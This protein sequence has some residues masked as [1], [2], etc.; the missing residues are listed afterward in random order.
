ML[1]ALYVLYVATRLTEFSP[2]SLELGDME[3]Q[4]VQALLERFLAR[5]PSAD[6]ATLLRREPGFS[7][8]WKNS[9]GQVE[10]FQQAPQRLRWAGWKRQL[11]WTPPGRRRALVLRFEAPRGLI[12]LLDRQGLQR[13][14]RS[15]LT[16]C[17]LA[18]LGVACVSQLFAD[19]LRRL[20]LLPEAPAP[21]T[22]P[23]VA[24]VERAFLLAA[25]QLA[26]SRSAQ[27]A[28]L[29]EAAA[30]ER[31]K[32]Q[33]LSTISHDLRTPL[34]VVL[35]RLAD[36]DPLRQV[37][38]RLLARL[39]R[40]LESAR[41]E[42]GRVGLH[43]E[44]FEWGEVLESALGRVEGVQ[45]QGDPSRLLRSDFRWLRR[46]LQCLLRGCSGPVEL[47]LEEK[48]VRVSCE[49][50]RFCC[51]EA[52]LTPAEIATVTAALGLNLRL[53]DGAG[54]FTLEFGQAP[55][56]PRPATEP[57]AVAVAP[58]RP[59][60]SGL[61]RRALFFL[62]LCLLWLAAL[63]IATAWLLPEGLQRWNELHQEVAHLRGLPC[64]PPATGL[65]L[66]QPEHTPALRC[67]SLSALTLAAAGPL[68]C[69]WLLRKRLRQLREAG[70]R[71]G[72][73]EPVGASP[74]PELDA[75]WVKL[76]TLQG[77]LGLEAAALQQQLKEVGTEHERRAL[78]L[79]RLQQQLA[80]EL[81][82][83]TES[84]RASQEASLRAAGETLAFLGQDLASA[85]RWERDRWPLE[86]TT[87]DASR[88][89]TQACQQLEPLLQ[90]RGLSWVWESPEGEAEQATTAE[91]AAN[92][93]TAD[94]AT[95]DV[96]TADAATAD[97]ATAVWVQADP[98]R[99][100]Q[101]LQNVLGNALKYAPP[102]GEVTLRWCR[103]GQHTVL[104]VADRGPGL[105]EEVA[106][107]PEREFSQAGEAGRRRLG[108][109]GLGLAIAHRS[110]EMMGGEL[111]LAARPGG[112][113]C[114]G[115]SMRSA[116]NLHKVALDV[117]AAEAH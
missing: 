34:T 55:A 114:V 61:A 50:F 21:G 67:L 5:S 86:M 18:T 41:L 46:L 70:E 73:G 63:A 103:K 94:V 39:E 90:E 97:V 47:S 82:P 15:G 113:S 92:S 53:H 88:F 6:P 29:A 89:V 25:Q 110:L 68:L 65:V 26:A 64:P 36:T 31:H 35:A 59:A 30:G 95:A 83:L 48:G 76:R 107:S 12:W 37:C 54:G 69:F 93:A 77:R 33:V 44:E 20:S 38:T 3:L 4:R 9:A 74:A 72:R 23:D 106:A 91:A 10:W 71:L 96:A 57:A 22:D 28:A 115:L 102:G 62:T 98:R 7:G 112:G 80:P 13:L 45:L 87:L 43:L 79:E 52:E 109:V 8:G 105:P 101:A 108:G 56:E 66:L 42:S 40:V 14:A 2:R 58:P 49:C 17:L 19:R 117:H 116:Q 60:W 51:D 16:L 99:L 104:T 81:E 84:C 27:R 111:Q 78:L 32:A 24:P 85:G 100:A 1:S 11:E 75:P